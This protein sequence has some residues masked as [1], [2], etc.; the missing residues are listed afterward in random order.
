M[1][2]PLF[3][4]C[5]KCAN[6]KYI[7]ISLYFRSSQNLSENRGT[8]PNTIARGPNIPQYPVGYPPTPTSTSGYPNNAGYHPTNAGYPPNAGGYPP[9]AG[10][11]PNAGYQPQG[12]TPMYHHVHHQPPP[13]AQQSASPDQERFY[14]NLSVYRNHDQHNGFVPGRAK[15]PSPHDER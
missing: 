14:Q 5:N 13:Q 1:L 3:F 12:Y 11:P 8:V 6:V 4:P 10:Y 15:L 2:I 9:G 7:F